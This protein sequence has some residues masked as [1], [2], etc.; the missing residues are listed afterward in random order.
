[1]KIK[2]IGI[3]RY[4]FYSKYKEFIKNYFEY[5]GYNVVLSSKYPEII[6]NKLRCNVYNKY[7]SHINNLTNKCDIILVPYMYENTTDETICPILEN[8]HTIIFNDI[9][10]IITFN[11]NNSVTI[12]KNTIKIDKNIP[13]IIIS[14]LLAKL[15]YKKSIK[16]Q[17]NA[18]RELFQSNRKKILIVTDEY[19]EE[20]ININPEYATLYS[21]YLDEKTAIDY[22]RTHP[23][24]TKLYSIKLMLG[25]I[26]YYNF[27]VDKI[28]IIY[29]NN[30][31]YDILKHIKNLPNNIQKKISIS[32]N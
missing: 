23:Q 28:L 11:L 32:K 1:M 18:Q 5:L 31:K 4:L 22:Y 3:P 27:T 10:N 30:C 15:D 17:Q 8:I 6:K 7:L 29:H 12:I 20:K 26:Y 21:K 24:K 25:S 19:Y 2:T 14:Y 13:K 9:K 16:K